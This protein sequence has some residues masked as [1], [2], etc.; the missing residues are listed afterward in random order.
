VGPSGLAGRGASDVV[1]H[2]PDDPLENTLLEA[3]V[4]NSGVAPSR[5]YIDGVA[6]NRGLAHPVGL[7]WTP[8]GRFLY[9][10]AAQYMW[11]ENGDWTIGGRGDNGTVAAYRYGGA[12]L[13]LAGA[14]GPGMGP[15]PWVRGAPPPA[16]ITI[17]DGALYTNDPEVELSITAPQG[18]ASLRLSND[19]DFGAPPIRLSDDG[20]YRWRLA[21][22]APERAVDRVYGRFTD[23]GWDGGTPLQDLTDDIILDQR[24]P[25]VLRAVLRG[26]RLSL[27]ARDNRSG[28]RWLQVTSKRTSPGPQLRFRR[29]VRLRRSQAKRRLYARVVDGAGNASRW[30]AVKR[31]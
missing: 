3:Q 22:T 7:A 14:L 31:R 2:R 9:V 16:S 5:R 24:P 21:D 26:S 1:G 23:P 25:A 18:V 11:R 20:R 29:R 17:N 4:T 27:R 19:G 28:V 8:D 10:A 13:E 30:R 6:G 15:W 12:G